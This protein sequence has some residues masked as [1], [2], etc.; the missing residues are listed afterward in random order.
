MSITLPWPPKELSPNAR[1]HWAKK[2]KA[3]KA[4]RAA[5]YLLTKQAGVIAPEGQLLF[6]IEFCPPDRRLRDDDNCLAAMKSGRDGIADALGVDDRRFVT[7]LRM[8]LP[9][10]GGSVLV[11]IEGEV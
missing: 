9:V 3:A 5:C 7:T 8:G 2:S 6:D 10:K 11:K 4:Y 1:T